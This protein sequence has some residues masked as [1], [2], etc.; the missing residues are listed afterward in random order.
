[1]NWFIFHTVLCAIAGWVYFEHLV[2]PGMILSPWAK[3]L[4]IKIGTL[5]KGGPINWI[6]KPLIGCVYCVS[7]Q[8]ALWSYLWV[9][10]ITQYDI[11]YHTMFVCCTIFMIDVI[12]RLINGVKN[13]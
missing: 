11:W 12:K 9:V 7:G 2:K 6:Y 13:D 5:R 8:I 4:N 10:D 3:F 1:M